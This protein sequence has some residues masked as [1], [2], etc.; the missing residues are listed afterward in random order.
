MFSQPRK[1][2]SESHTQDR[3]KIETRED[4]EE[5]EKVEEKKKASLQAK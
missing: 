1:N 3:K 5:E 2:S 4:V